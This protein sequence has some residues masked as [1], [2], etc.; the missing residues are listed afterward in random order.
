M[1]NN[2]YQDYVHEMFILIG[3]I[4]KLHPIYYLNKGYF[5]T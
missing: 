3:M 5:Q 2:I 1:K 4:Q